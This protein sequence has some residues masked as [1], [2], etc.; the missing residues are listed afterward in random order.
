MME[1]WAS[2]LAD[3]DA[4]LNEEV[5]IHCIGGFAVT[6]QFGLSRQTSDID[7]LSIA[8]NSQAELV[9][10]LAG[11]GGALHH[12]HGVY[13][14]LM[15]AIV[16]LPESYEDHAKDLFPGRYKNLRVVGLDP[17]DLALSKLER[18]LQRDRED[19]K[20]LYKAVPLDVDTLEERYRTE[21]RPYFPEQVRI[22]LDLTLNLWLDM[23]KEA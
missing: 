19:V 16:T 2:F 1:P 11:E 18:N 22:K 8:P 23:F 15:G 3:L 9:S 6:V 5:C 7:V 12:K 17:Y 21:Q 13:I 4:E 10:N 20:F 14:Q